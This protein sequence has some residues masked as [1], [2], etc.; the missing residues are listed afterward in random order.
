MVVGRRS[1]PFGSRPIF[2]GELL[3]FGR[4]RL[5]GTHGV[6]DDLVITSFD[7]TPYAGPWVVS[8]EPCGFGGVTNKNQRK[9]REKRHLRTLLDGSCYFSQPLVSWMTFNSWTFMGPKNTCQLKRRVSFFVYTT[10]L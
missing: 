5:V 9:N 7:P 6:S 1:F 3:N 10:P 4:V 8:M 2:S